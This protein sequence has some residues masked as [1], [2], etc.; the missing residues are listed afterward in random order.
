MD[1]KVEAIDFL[2]SHFNQEC[3]FLKVSNFK[4]S[5]INFKPYTSA[6]N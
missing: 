6:Y 4:N 3:K 1:F 5:Q 2:R